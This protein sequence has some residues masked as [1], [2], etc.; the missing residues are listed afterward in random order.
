[1]VD[2]W[3]A[4]SIKVAELLK[5]GCWQEC[6]ERQIATDW[7]ACHRDNGGNANGKVWG[8]T[9]E[10]AARGRGSETKKIILVNFEIPNN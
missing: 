6:A 4:G 1:M 2:R 10:Q 3:G 5:S 9:V 8:M 7:D